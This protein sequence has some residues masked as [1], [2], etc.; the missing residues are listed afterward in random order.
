MLSNS[1]RATMPLASGRQTIRNLLASCSRLSPGCI[2]SLCSA[3]AGF[4]RLHSRSNFAVVG[5]F[6]GGGRVRRPRG[7]SPAA[8]SGRRSRLRSRPRLRQ[9]SLPTKPIQNG[10]LQEG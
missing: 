3:D 6:D 7:K 8:R 1:D 10:R 9:D 4:G 2:T 5:D